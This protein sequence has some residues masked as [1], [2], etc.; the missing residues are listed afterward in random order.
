MRADVG[1]VSNPTLLKHRRELEPRPP[2]FRG[3][4]L[5]RSLRVVFREKLI[6]RDVWG[7]SV[8]HPRQP[9]EELEREAAVTERPQ[10]ADRDIGLALIRSV[11][12]RTHP[13]SFPRHG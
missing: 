12:G 13:T 5:P 7:G 6:D 10:A 9:V 3:K 11:M 4:V 2:R 8:V 1:N